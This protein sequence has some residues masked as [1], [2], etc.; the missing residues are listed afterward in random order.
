MW[1]LHGI[2]ICIVATG[3]LYLVYQIGRFYKT[4]ADLEERYALFEIAMINKRA[5]IKNINLDKEKSKLRTY[6]MLE[7]KR[8]FKNELK[9]E[10]INDMFGNDKAIE[11]QKILREIKVWTNKKKEHK[12][13]KI[14][15]AKENMKE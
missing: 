3:I 15:W 1:E 8:T 5:Y 12:G 11:K 4:T 7:G 2:A 9:K 14:K 13:D 6:K 10:I